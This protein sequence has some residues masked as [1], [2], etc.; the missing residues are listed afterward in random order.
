MSVPLH[1]EDF[2]IGDPIPN[3][4][5]LEL[6]NNKMVLKV[7]RYKTK[8]LKQPLATCKNEVVKEVITLWNSSSLQTKRQEKCVIVLTKLLTEYREIQKRAGQENNKKKEEK[9]EK[10]LEQLFDIAPKSK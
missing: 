6:P 7:L 3:F 4:P 5:N 1:G 9:F 8:K 2:L 10:K